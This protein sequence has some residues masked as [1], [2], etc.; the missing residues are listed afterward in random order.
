MEAGLCPFL[1]S[2]FQPSGSLALGLRRRFQ[3]RS[4]LLRA[5]FPLRGGQAAA[6]AGQSLGRSLPPSDALDVAALAMRR[7]LADRTA[8]DISFISKLQASATD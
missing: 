7:E 1:G 3:K 5:W 6:A 4:G 8:E 2:S